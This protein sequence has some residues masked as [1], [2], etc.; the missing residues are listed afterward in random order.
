MMRERSL[1]T[2]VK[3]THTH[4]PMFIQP[5]T[6]AQTHTNKQQTGWDK[7]ERGGSERAG[8]LAAVALALFLPL[9]RWSLERCLNC[10][11]CRKICDHICECIQV[12]GGSSPRREAVEFVCR[13]LGNYKWQI[14][15]NEAGGA[16]GGV[17]RWRRNRRKKTKQTEL[18]AKCVITLWQMTFGRFRKKL[19][20]VA[21]SQ[22]ATASRVTLILD[23]HRPGQV[24]FLCASLRRKG[25]L[26]ERKHKSNTTSSSNYN[27]GKSR[28]DR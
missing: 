26:T 5:H 17:S 14:H 19:W 27:Q 25:S 3:H 16:A 13:P 21:G 18:T 8:E 12:A 22:R 15:K 9:L 28:E 20:K 1:Q 7:H 24:L 10:K 2:R 11:T 4:T 23:H 6:C